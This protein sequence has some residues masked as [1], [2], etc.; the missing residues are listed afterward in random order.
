MDFWRCSNRQVSPNDFWW[1]EGSGSLVSVYF[2]VSLDKLKLITI[3]HSAWL[4][5]II[6]APATDL[7][8]SSD[9]IIVLCGSTWES[10]MRGVGKEEDKQKSK[11]ASEFNIQFSDE[12]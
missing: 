11:D 1:I 10:Q 5:T 4:N 9:I 7:N 2:Y 6:I 3:S 12:S 8:S